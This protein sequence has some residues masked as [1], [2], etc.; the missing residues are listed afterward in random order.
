MHRS[1]FRFL[2][3]R[4]LHR[5]RRGVFPHAITVNVTNRAYGI[6]TVAQDPAVRSPDENTVN[7]R[8]VGL[9]IKKGVRKNRFD[10]AR[11]NGRVFGEHTLPGDA[12]RNK[13]NLASGKKPNPSMCIISRN[14]LYYYTLSALFF[15]PH[16]PPRPPILHR[17]HTYVYVYSLWPCRPTVSDVN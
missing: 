6:I 9:I 16:S 7:K 8:A 1:T 5:S 3:V 13:T 17:I 4:R 11:T 14:R 15:S 12:R 10:F 2:S